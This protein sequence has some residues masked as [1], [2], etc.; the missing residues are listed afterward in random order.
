MTRPPAIRLYENEVVIDEFAG[1][2]GASTGIEWAIGRSPDVAINH[3][4]EALAMH[5]KN[6]PDTHHI[7]TDVYRV[8]P[9]DATGGKPCAFAWFSPDC[10]YFSKARGAKPFRD[11]KWARR[12]RGLAWVVVKWARTPLPSKP[13][14]IFVENLAEAL[15]RANL[16]A[17]A[18]ESAT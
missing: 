6:H 5:A 2:G 4:I 14:V 17:R 12:V 16:G 11:L 8:E 3:D 15:V 13:R 10:T 1:G 18:V 9:L 7:P